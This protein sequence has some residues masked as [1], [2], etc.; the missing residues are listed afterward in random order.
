MRKESHHVIVEPGSDAGFLTPP[1][2]PR[3]IQHTPV[4]T[5]DCLE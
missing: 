5:G 3:L 2:L 4:P 1:L